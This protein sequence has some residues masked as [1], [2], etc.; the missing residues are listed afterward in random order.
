MT[1]TDTVCGTGGWSGPLPGDPDNNVVIS[2]TGGYGGINVSWT[3]PATNPFAV[4]HTLLYRGRSANFN[5]AVQIAVVAG[6]IFFDRLANE[7][8]PFT[9]YYWIKIVSSNGTTGDPVGPASAVAIPKY[10]ETLESLTGRIDSGLL[11]ESLREEIARI[12]LVG[13]GLTQEILDRIT[14]NEALAAA[15]A[16]VQAENGQA[17]TYILDEVTSRTSAD[18]AM[19]SSIQAI[20]AGLE[21]NAAALLEE[22]TVRVT[23]DDATAAS[24][25]VLFTKTAD[26]LA[27]IQNEQTART[28][29]DEALATSISTIVGSYQ[30]N[31]AA[32]QAEATARATAD[33]NLAN[34]IT[35]A[36]STLNGNISSVQ[37]SLTSRINTTDGKVSSIGALYTAK[38]NVNG[39]IGGFGVYNNGTE[40]Q[41]G[42]DVDTFWVGRTNA[43]KVKPFIITGGVVYID[44]ARIKD[45]DITTLKLAGNSV[46]VQ[47]QGQGAASAVCSVYLPYGGKAF[48]VAQTYAQ[49][50]SGATSLTAQITCSNGQVSMNMG[51][52]LVSD[53]AGPADGSIMVSAVFTLGGGTHTFTVNAACPNRNTFTSNIAAFASQR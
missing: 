22:K 9:H 37:T 20:A 52:R 8:I 49:G 45:A 12:S 5:S 28:S 44:S 27:A 1:C 47:A 17:L 14:S 40:V 30:D 41:A 31:T 18:E 23:K 33:T 53:G 51:Q 2:A 38:V 19:V 7:D 50:G 10:V 4:A 43:D 24:L 48:V 3:Y 26:N 13:N 42:F 39:L 29:A 15:L 11:A 16:A 32:V 25:E 35:T 21:D 34:R 46:T 36:Q 6:S